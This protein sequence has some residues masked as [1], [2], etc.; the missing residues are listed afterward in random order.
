MI[1]RISTIADPEG[2]SKQYDKISPEKEPIIAMIMLNR[3]IVSMFLDKH[4]AAIAGIKIIASPIKIP[5]TKK[6]EIRFI[7]RSE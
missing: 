6:E 4:L 3:R 1:P 7:I 2:I 5:K